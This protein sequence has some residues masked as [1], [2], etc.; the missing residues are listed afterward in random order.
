MTGKVMLFA[1]IAYITVT[2]LER[3][4]VSL[5][6]RLLAVAGFDSHV[7]A[8][9]STPLRFEYFSYAPSIIAA[10]LPGIRVEF[11]AKTKSRVDKK[12]PQV[13]TSVKSMLFFLLLLLF[14]LVMSSS[15]GSFS[16]Q[17]LALGRQL[18][19]DCWWVCLF[20]VSRTSSW[21]L[22]TTWSVRTGTTC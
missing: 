15:R 10:K 4:C 13:C 8:E 22:R 11:T 19:T 3:C 2:W 1:L 18:L 20:L 12:K 9:F 16:Y 17:T 21:H 6:C 5:T 14:F 7:M